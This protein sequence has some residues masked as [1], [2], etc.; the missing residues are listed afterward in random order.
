[1]GNITETSNAINTDKKLE[2]ENQNL[3]NEILYYK[4][5]VTRMEDMKMYKYVKNNS[6]DNIIKN[7]K[8]YDYENLVFEGGGSKGACYAG[9]CEQ[10]EKLKI[11]KKIKRFAGSSVGSLIA[12]V[13]AIGYSASE[14]KELI[15]TTDFGELIKSNYILDTI[16]L[17]EDFGMISG[18]K[19][20]ELVGHLIEKKKRKADYTFKELFD[21]DGIV[22]VI[23]STNINELR[24]DYFYHVNHPD[25][26][27]KEAVRMSVSIPY[28]FE[29]VKMFGS[30]YVDGGV[31]DN[32]PIHV[33]DGEFPGD[34]NAK[35]N[36][37]PPN[38]KTLGIKIFTPDEE[39]D[40]Q[41]HKR[42]KINSVISFSE[43]LIDTLLISA[44]RKYMRPAYWVRSIVIKTPAIPLTKFSLTKEQKNTLYKNGIDGTNKF[45]NK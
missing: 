19:L 45:F 29:P 5:I 43:A 15:M 11:L 24:T 34:K 36:L 20:S 40:Y 44:T 3:K 12:T 33:F 17:V 39:E 1:M 9:A 21:D 4:K 25:M 2:K 22:L 23:T 18:R 10:L 7:K 31:L 42:E 28:L 6:L 8:S 37:V 16:C 41:A 32:Y 38:P 14:V 13:L 35:L 27:I 30:Y 26:P